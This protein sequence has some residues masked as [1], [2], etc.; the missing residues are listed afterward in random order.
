MIKNNEFYILRHGET[1]YQTDKKHRVYP[2]KGSLN[3]I[4]LTV[5]GRQQIKEAALKLKNKKIDR[6]YASDFLRT[7]QT[8]LIIARTISLSRKRIVFTKKLRDINLGIYHGKAKEKFYREMGEVPINFNYK[9]KKGES[10]NEVLKR[11]VNFIK[12]IDNKYKNNAILIISHGEPLWLLDGFLKKINKEKL[13]DKNFVKKNYIQTG[14]L[15]KLK[16]E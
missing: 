6:I 11:M 5:K 3:S 14:E 7:K 13:I 16:N 15:K 2:F 10:L 4:R 12:E 1:I 9:I 8:S